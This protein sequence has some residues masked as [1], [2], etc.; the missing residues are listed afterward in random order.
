MTVDYVKEQK[1]YEYYAIVIVCSL[2]LYVH[3]GHCINGFNGNI[4]EY[5]IL[6]NTIANKIILF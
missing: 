6:V 3:V 5:S 4:S 1:R 2:E